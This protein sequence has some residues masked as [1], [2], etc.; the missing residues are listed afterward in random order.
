MRKEV[1]GARGLVLGNN[2]SCALCGGFWSF[3]LRCAGFRL[4]LRSLA[5]GSS[6]CC[7]FKDVR[8]FTAVII[9]Q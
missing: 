8:N 3:A 2:G 1:R 7:C 6:S 5:H 9:Q 4:E